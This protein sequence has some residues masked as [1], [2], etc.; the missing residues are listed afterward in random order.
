MAAR[1]SAPRSVA[2]LQAAAGGR[3]TH[4]STAATTR[5]APRLGSWT[6]SRVAAAEKTPSGNTNPHQPAG[7]GSGPAVGVGDQAGRQAGR[8]GSNWHCK[9]SSAP[10]SAPPMHS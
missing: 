3:L 2:Q 6:H 4:M 8:P 7:S 10:R 5:I 9:S 1:C